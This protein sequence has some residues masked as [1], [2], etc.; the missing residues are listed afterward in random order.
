MARLTEYSI[1]PT[2]IDTL[3]DTQKYQWYLYAKDLCKSLIGTELIELT[4]AIR[5][6]EK[7]NE[8]K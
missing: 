5:Q 1:S 3:S 7:I 2:W 4:N 6:Y 8:V